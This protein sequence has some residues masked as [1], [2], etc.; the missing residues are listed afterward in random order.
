MR[1]G[2]RAVELNPGDPD[3]LMALAKAQVRFGAYAEAV[4]NAERARRLHPMAPEYY[5]YVHGQA[6]YAADRPAEAEEVLAE[7]LMRAPQEPNCLKIRAAVLVR[8][9][10]PDEARDSLAQL[11]RDRA[12]LLACR[13][14][15]HP[16]LRQFAADAA[17]PRRSRRRGGPAIGRRSGPG[18]E[19]RGV[20]TRTLTIY[21][22]RAARLRKLE[23][24]LA[25][26]CRPVTHA[27]ALPRKPRKRMRRGAESGKGCS[28]M[29][30]LIEGKWVDR[31]P[32]PAPDGQFHRVESRFR[33]WVTVDGAPGPTGE[34]GFK[35]EPG[36][37]PPLCLARLP[38]GAPHAD[39]PAAEE[40]DRGDRRLVRRAAHAGRRLDV[41]RRV[42]GPSLRHPAA[43]RDLPEGRSRLFRPGD[44][45][46]PVGQAAGEDRLQRIGRHHPH[47]E[48]GLRRLRRALARLLPGD[49]APR[50]RCHERGRLR[51]RQQRRLQGR[52]RHQPGS[53][54]GGV[55][56]ALQ[57]AR[58]ARREARR[59]AFPA[60]RPADRGGLAA[61]H[62]ADALRRR[63]ITATSSA[64][65]AA[66][67][68]TRTSQAIS[69]TSS[70]C[71]ASRRRSTSS[72][73]SSTITTAT[74]GSTRRASCR[75]GRC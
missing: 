38:L 10:R 72:T 6:L 30:M 17:L 7:C 11:R 29:G 24:R 15:R 71:P 41:Q 13:R 26:R 60:R 70:R 19:P 33:N 2:E 64:T 47:A 32:E 55:P 51:E 8:L 57:H 31:R 45:A 56:R 20:E 5:A 62:D 63:S 35:A 42:A 21:P 74:T 61:V 68:T 73:S 52:L 54:R 27:P 44:D 9:G 1:A 14:T 66:S 75:S 22:G 25:A 50:D 36:P 39:L 59:A 37:L 46:G 16:P 3:S 4:G 49:A 28:R 40:A 53:L 18:G 48:L 69:A 67:P 34:G 65:A 23:R 43:L 12:G 58:R